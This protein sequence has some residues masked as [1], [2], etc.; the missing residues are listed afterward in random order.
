M[1]TSVLF[2]L[3]RLPFG[4]CQLAPTASSMHS[5][6]LTVDHSR[7]APV[8][9]TLIIV[10]P[11]VNTARTIANIMPTAQIGTVS[12]VTQKVSVASPK[13]ARKTC[14]ATAAESLAF[15]WRFRD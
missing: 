2:G 8:I 6:A 5:I 13:Q 10:I 1:S 14:S 15:E 3:G 7:L 11:S 4:R 9:A 12:T